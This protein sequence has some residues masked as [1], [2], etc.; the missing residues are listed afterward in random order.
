MK[1]KLIAKSKK[2]KERI[3]RDGEWWHVLKV[4][5]EAL[6]FSAGD[7][8]PWL[9]LEAEKTHDTR[10]VRQTHDTDFLVED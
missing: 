8:G 2:G 10:W 3:K 5:A 4:V 1:V 7:V 6:P 9:F